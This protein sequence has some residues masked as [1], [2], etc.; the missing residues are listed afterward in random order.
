[1][2]GN[3]FK[4]ALRIL[5]KYKSYT[6]VNILALAT[7]L[8]CSIIIFL[9]AEYEYSF[10]RFHRNAKNIYRIGIRGNVSGNKLN[11]AVTAAPLAPTLEKEFPEIKRAVR[12]GRFGAWLV[13]YDKI[14]FNED[15]IIFAD[16]AFFNLFSFP[17]IAGDP[18]IVLSKPESIVLSKKA[19]QRYFGTEKNVL[20]KKLRIENDSTYYEVTG[21]MEDIPHNSHIHFD[22]VASLSTLYKYLHHDSWIMNNFYTYLQVEEGADKKLLKEKLNGLVEKYVEPAYYE[23]INLEKNEIKGINDRYEFVLQPLLD[24]HLKSDFEVELEPAGNIQYVYIFTSIALLILIV[25][26]INFMNLA[27]ATTA[28]RAREVGIRKIAGSDKKV[29]IRQFLTESLLITFLSLVM[30]LLFAELLLPL[31][32]QYINLHLSLSQLATPKGL[33]W[34]FA[35]VTIVGLFAGLYPAFFLSS[36]DPIV[37]MRTWLRHGS[38]SNFLRTGLVFFQFFVAIAILTMTFIIYAQFNFTMNKNLGFN[39]ENLVVIRRPDGLKKNL[40]NYRNAILINEQVLQATNTLSLPGNIVNSNTFYLENTSPEENYHLTFHLVN[41]DFLN[42]YDIKLSEGRFFDPIVST[43]SSACVINETAARIVGLKDPIGKKLVMLYSKSGE[44]M[45]F[46]IIGVVKDFNFQPLE[47]PVG[48]LIMFLI[49]GNP[50]G[51]LTVKISSRDKEQTINFLQSEW[52]KFTSDYPFVY[53]FLDDHL[54]EHYLDIRKTARI[55]LILSVIAVFIA[56]LGL[57]GLVS[58]TT[59]QRTREIGIRKT[60]GASILRLF[61]LQ[62]REILLLIAFSSV[63]AW[64]LVYFIAVSWLREFYYHIPLTPVYFL[65]AMVIVLLIAILTVSRQTY[66]AAGINPGQAIRYE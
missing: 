65:M 50:E 39:K 16:S 13:R 10:D 45:K 15:N 33:L 5:Y 41:Y 30:A 35:L 19:A 42:T 44:T 26:C 6:L 47:N 3:F 59:S 29:L 52:E 25:A 46:E 55:F 24:I 2:T 20:G 38:S 14:K 18:S 7:G 61:L 56:C 12:V 40:D 32:N 62:L 57:F 21:I 48:A 63:L 64:G 43:D 4:V 37:V 36:F 34:L 66:M 1:M 9:Y 58:Y 49:H 17:L 53:F 54:K 27:T 23:M 22:M 31:F 8:S 51:Y 60:M 28:N 11:H